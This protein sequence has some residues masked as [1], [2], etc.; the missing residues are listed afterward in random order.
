MRFP[1]AHLPQVIPVGVQT[2]SGVEE[3]GIDVSVW[4]TKWPDMTFTVWLTR[5]GESAA[6]P[7]N[8]VRLDGTL[9]IW[10]PDGY[11]TS[12]SGSGKL[13][14]L[15]RTADGEARKLTGDGVATLIRG[16]TLATTAEPGE[17]EKP[18]VDAVLDAATRAE[19]A[20]K[21]AEDAGSGSVPIATKDRLGVVKVGDGLSI[22]DDGVLSAKG[23]GS[24]GVTPEQVQE[25]VNEALQNAKDSGEFDGPP[26]PAGEKGDKGDPGET[27]P[28]GPQGEQGPAGISAT[29]HWN[30][31]VLTMTSESGTSS[32]DLKGAPGDPGHTPVRGKEYWTA[33]D[34]QQIVSDVLSALPTWTGGAY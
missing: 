30:G 19:E 4:R 27:G 3:I 9:L 21:R 22:T 23:G 10:L 29:H 5:P 7:A 34:Q 31:T 1:I 8:D 33:S 11:D 17:A 6:Y 14:V 25:A 20:A 26:G 13:E 12:V 2:E 15:G 32:A 28:Q 18:W 24:G 16:T